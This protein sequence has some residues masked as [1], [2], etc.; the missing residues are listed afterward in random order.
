MAFLL[1]DYSISFSRLCFCV[2]L[3]EAKIPRITRALTFESTQSVFR[4]YWDFL[5]FC[6]H[7]TP[8]HL[9]LSIFTSD[10]I[11]RL[12]IAIASCASSI[13]TFLAWLTVRGSFILIKV[14]HIWPR[15]QQILPKHHAVLFFIQS[16][17][18][19]KWRV[20]STQGDPPLWLACERKR[21]LS[22]FK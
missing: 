11:D 16:G 2:N 18:N 12:S 6:C 17:I 15:V 1:L 3:V 4:V 14:W 10:C 5:S 19:T 8:L 9:L 21:T 13:F 22:I 20:C 7:T